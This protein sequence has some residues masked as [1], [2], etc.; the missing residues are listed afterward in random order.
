[1]LTP[2]SYSSD[3]VHTTVVNSAYVSSELIHR[4]ASDVPNED[5]V[6]HIHCVGCEVMPHEQTV[7]R[8]VYSQNIHDMFV[9]CYSK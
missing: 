1:M 6:Q 2:P 3:D 8:S 7:F 4:L 5:D 9:F